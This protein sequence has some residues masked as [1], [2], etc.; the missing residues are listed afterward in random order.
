MKPPGRAARPTIPVRP[1]TRVQ[2]PAGPG[3]RSSGDEHERN[4]RSP[5]GAAGSRF[6][7]PRIN[8]ATSGDAAPGFRWRATRATGLLRG[9]FGRGQDDQVRRAQHHQRCGRAGE[10]ADLEAEMLGDARRQQVEHGRRVDACVAVQKRAKL[11]VAGQPLHSRLSP[12][13][14]FGLISQNARG[15]VKRGHS[16]DEVAGLGRLR[17]EAVQILFNWRYC[18]QTALKSM[19]P[20][21]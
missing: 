5:D 20:K 7:R 9:E 12:G 1:R 2:P 13:L 8:S 15:P 14:D 10:Q 3:T 4:V 16:L 19:C 18:V 17:T 11:F 6:A 21:S